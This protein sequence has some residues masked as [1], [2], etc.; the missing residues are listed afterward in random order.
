MH[1]TRSLTT[2]LN[3]DL[4]GLRCLVRGFLL[5]LVLTSTPTLQLRSKFFRSKIFG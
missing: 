3:E 2:R 4:V 1:P 5:V